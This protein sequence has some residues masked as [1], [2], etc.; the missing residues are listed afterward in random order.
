MATLKVFE[1]VKIGDSVMVWRAS[2]RSYTT[3]R[4]LR[5]GFRR[6]GQPYFHMRQYEGDTP[7][8]MT[9]TCHPRRVS[10]LEGFVPELGPVW[11]ERGTR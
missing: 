10:A 3:C 8:C 5:F 2:Y 11:P 4:V 1:D 7:W 6:D 9:F